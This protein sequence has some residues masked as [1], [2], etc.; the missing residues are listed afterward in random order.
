MKY[1]IISISLDESSHTALNTR[2]KDLGMTRSEYVRKL[3]RDSMQ[4]DA[5]TK[6]PKP[7]PRT[8]RL[9]YMNAAV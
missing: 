1:K 6:K 9:P 4:P 8:K 5:A 7:R 2:L 3:L